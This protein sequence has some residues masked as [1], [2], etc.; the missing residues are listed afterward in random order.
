M[1]DRVGAGRVREGALVQI[2]DGRGRVWEGE[3][4]KGKSEISVDDGELVQARS[5]S[6]LLRSWWGAEPGSG[7]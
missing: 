7:Y 5:N 6:V 4:G 2:D 1:V 3:G